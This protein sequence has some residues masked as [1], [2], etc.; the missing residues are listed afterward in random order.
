MIR[1]IFRGG[2]LTVLV[3]ALL[4]VGAFSQ[5][6]V[7]D[8]SAIR[9]RESPVTIAYKGNVQKTKVMKPRIIYDGHLDYWDHGYNKAGHSYF[10]IL[11]T[12]EE[13]K[14]ILDLKSH[15]KYDEILKYVQQL[16]ND[17]CAEGNRKDISSF[18]YDSAGRRCYKVIKVSDGS[19]SHRGTSSSI[20]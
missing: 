13:E 8:L 4:N 19:F 15:Y 6:I 17:R 10:Q 7:K 5:D 2:V 16:L 3:S 1:N 9:N 12:E 18:L 20:R 11:L 14:K